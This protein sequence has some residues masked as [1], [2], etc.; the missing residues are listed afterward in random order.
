MITSQLTFSKLRV[1]DDSLHH[2]RI[3]FPP[4]LRL[5]SHLRVWGRQSQKEIHRIVGRPSSERSSCTSFGRLASLDSVCAFL[6]RLLP[7]KN[8]A[9]FGVLLKSMG[10]APGTHRRPM[11]CRYCEWLADSRQFRP[12]FGMRRCE[13]SLKRQLA[14]VCM[15]S[16]KT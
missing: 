12:Q 13:R 8:R 15:A 3:T 1:T 4:P 5:C 10:N 7:D 14:C 6:P 9:A 16:F 2:T 11:I